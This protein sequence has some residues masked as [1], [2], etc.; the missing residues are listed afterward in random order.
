MMFIQV[1][2][3]H[4]GFRR[5]ASDHQMEY[6]ARMIAPHPAYAINVASTL[7]PEFSPT[8]YGMAG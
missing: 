1:L 4:V 5:A 6:N 3:I 2:L 7:D 8:L